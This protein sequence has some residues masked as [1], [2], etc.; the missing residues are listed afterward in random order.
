VR[1]AL[2]RSGWGWLAATIGSYAAGF[3][4]GYRTLHAV[5]VGMAA[6]LLLSAAGVAVRPRVQIN[7]GVQPDRLTAGEPALGRMTVRNLARWRSPGFVAVDRIDGRPLELPVAGLAGGGRRT[8]HYPVP[9][10]R[11]G[12]LELG[13]LVVERRDPLGLLRRAQRH[14]ASAVLWVHPVTYPVRPLPV[15]RVP[16]FEGRRADTA[17][18]GTVTFSSL[19]EYV[20]GDDPRRIHWRTTARTG[21]LI[22]REHIDTTEPTTTVL[23]DT[24]AAALD[25]E[26]FEYAVQAAASVAE[27][28]V[29]AGRPARVAILGEDP[30]RVARLGAVSLLDRFAAAEQTGAGDAL[31]LMETIER[32]PPGGALVVVTGRPDPTLAT[33]LAAQRR[34]FAPVVVLAVLGTADSA[35]LPAYRRPGMV[36]LSARTGSEAALAWDHMVLGELR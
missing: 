12:R 19:R 18:S 9:T 4:L 2:T 24:R 5:A 31:V 10:P 28:T 3:A 6:L 1:S 17:R 29:R 8:L 30:V 16:D 36:L 13:P 32:T 23:L 26:A 21:T 20:P 35:P 25:P 34:R 22:V 15:G 11:R 7:R 14:A 33:R 27:A